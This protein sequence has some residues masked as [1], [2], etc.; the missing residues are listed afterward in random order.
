ML[1]G[2][3]AL[4]VSPTPLGNTSVHSPYTVTSTLPSGLGS[5]VERTESTL[6]VMLERA[7]AS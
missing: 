4:N 5:R 2:N 3:Q 7:P 6:K 1:P